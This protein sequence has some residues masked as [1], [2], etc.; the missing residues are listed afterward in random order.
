MKPKLLL[1]FAFLLT[2]CFGKTEEDALLHVRSVRSG[3]RVSMELMQRAEAKESLPAALAGTVSGA[4]MGG[5][6]D[7]PDSIPPSIPSGIA[8]NEVKVDTELLAE[9]IQLL[10]IDVRD[11]LNA[12]TNRERTFN[13][14]HQSMESHTQRGNLRMRALEDRTEELRDD[15]RRLSRSVR[16]LKEELDQAIGEGKSTDASLIAGELTQKQSTLAKTETDL[17]IASRTLESY[18]DL[19]DPLQERLDAVS[20]NRPAL[21]QGISVVDIPGVEDL[22]IIEYDEGIPRFRKRR[23]GRF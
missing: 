21:I 23:R 6:G 16:D 8:K 9:V 7:I 15:E 4:M 22:G 13:Q 17:I 14:Y 18:E 5:G 20:A 10:Q 19:I 1:A 11:L 12:S 2:A 3:M